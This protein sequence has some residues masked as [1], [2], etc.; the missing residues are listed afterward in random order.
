M[1]CSRPGSTTPILRRRLHAVPKALSDLR[2]P[3]VGHQVPQAGAPRVLHLRVGQRKSGGQ[4][5]TNVADHRYN[6]TAAV[7]SNDTE[8]TRVSAKLLCQP[9]TGE[10]LDRQEDRSN[11]MMTFGEVPPQ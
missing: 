3:W 5:V 1:P 2:C 7:G 4:G 11:G 10:G 6:R 9:V 8:T